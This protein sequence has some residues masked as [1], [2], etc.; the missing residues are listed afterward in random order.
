MTGRTAFL[1]AYGYGN[2]GDEL[3]LIEA[4]QAFPPAEAHAF[5]VDG[6]WTRRCVPELAGTFREGPEML[7]LRPDRI[8]FGGGMFGVSDAFAAWMPWMAEAAEQGVA[9]HVHNIGVARIK[10]DLAW[11]DARAAATVARLASFTVRD[12]VSFEMIAEAGLGRMPRITHFPERLVTPDFA[13]ADELLPRGRKLLGVSILSLPAMEEVTERDAPLLDALLAEFEGH[14][15]VPV[16]STLHQSAEDENDVEGA[17]RFIR[18]FLPRAR[19]AAPE[20]LDAA[21]WRA[22]LTPRNLKGLIA[23]C[24]ALVTQRKHNAV[25]AIGAGVR[26][27]GLHPVVDDSLRRTFVALSEVLPPGSRCIGIGEV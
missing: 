10:S 1:G 19:I 2:L 26:V 20:L 23:R 11:F 4:M 24:D 12:Y 9:L 15:V 17:A 13:L 3:C 21:F 5:S 25:H 6:A 16:V 27:I 18:R 22:R 14:D 8:V 7:A